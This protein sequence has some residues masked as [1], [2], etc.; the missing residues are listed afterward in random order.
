MKI[1]IFILSFAQLC[2]FALSS[3]QAKA[4]P[5]TAGIVLMGGVMSAGVVGVIAAQPTRG[6]LTED[7]QTLNRNPQVSA[8]WEDIRE[9]SMSKA[10]VVPDQLK[11]V[12]GAMHLLYP[13][14]PH[15]DAEL[16]RYA[17]HCVGV[18]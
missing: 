18:N 4:D 1:R 8:L 13:S 12:V 14:D 10:D 15:S 3:S 2:A 5:I 9:F 7:C 6:K 11:P 16:V 17:G